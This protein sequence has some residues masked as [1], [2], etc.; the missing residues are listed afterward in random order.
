ML[1]LVRYFHFFLSVVLLLV[2]LMIYD[3]LFDVSFTARPPLLV[4]SHSALLKLTF[5]A[6]SNCVC[7]GMVKREKQSVVWWW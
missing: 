5:S 2:V 7:I 3:A 1:F 4:L 6:A